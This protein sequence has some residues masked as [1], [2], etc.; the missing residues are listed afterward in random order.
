MCLLGQYR[1]QWRFIITACSLQHR[2][3]RFEVFF[4]FDSLIKRGIEYNI[5]M[6]LE[7]GCEGV[8]WVSIGISG[9]LVLQ[10]VPCSTG[11]EDLRFSSPSDSLIK[12][13]IEYNIEMKL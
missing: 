8:Y 11:M 1:N 4:E 10:H 13:G 5:E 2:N 9:G 6:R 12:R 7:I 3:G